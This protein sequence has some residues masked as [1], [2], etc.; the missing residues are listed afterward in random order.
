MSENEEPERSNIVEMSLE[1]FQTNLENTIANHPD[2]FVKITV[3][4]GKIR[5]R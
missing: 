4:E 2:D 5:E 3:Q 1:G